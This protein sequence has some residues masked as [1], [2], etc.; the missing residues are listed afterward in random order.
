MQLWKVLI[1]GT[2]LAAVG[3]NSDPASTQDPSAKVAGT[4]P[5]GA[6]RA[7]LWLTMNAGAEGVN[8]VVNYERGNAAGPRVA[9]VMI[10]HS[11]SLELASSVPGDGATKAGK[12]LTVQHPKPG[13]LRLV[14]LSRDTKEIESGELAQLSFR[15][16]DK[17]PVKADLLMDKPV[18]APAEAMEGLMIGDPV[19]L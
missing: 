1:L 11:N 15:R 17:A 6:G 16:S 19:G 3:C 12:E 5:V 14:F 18:F 10:A 9:D 4:K 7:K 8:L 13:V 2:A